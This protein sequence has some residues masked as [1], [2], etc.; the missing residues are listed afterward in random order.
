MKIVFP[1]PVQGP[2]QVQGTAQERAA[3]ERAAAAPQS[4]P[5]AG[6]PAADAEIVRAAEAALKADVKTDGRIAEIKRSIQAGR[7]R[8][9]ADVLAT[10]I[11][12]FH[13]KQD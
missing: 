6:R 1:T 4:A 13:G 9:D 11:L 2:S 3:Q 7:I 12:R 10:M 5:D 8:F